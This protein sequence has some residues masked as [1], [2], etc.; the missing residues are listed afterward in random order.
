[1]DYVAVNLKD[2]I[3]INKLVTVH[4]F[5]YTKNYTFQGESHDF[6]ELVYVDKGQ[7]IAYAD[8]RVF[9]LKQ[10]QVVF[11]KP[12]EWH[13]INA[14]GVVAANVS[15]VSFV[16]N[17]KAMEGFE[18]LVYN[19][20][21]HQKE[22]LSKIVKESEDVFANPLND[23][24]TS[25]MIK[26]K[27]SQIGAEQLIKM[28]LTEFL[29]SVLRTKN[30]YEKNSSLSLIR[31]KTNNETTDTI[32]EYLSR[33]L[34]NK[35]TFTDVAKH[36][37]LSKTTI[38]TVFAQNT[39]MGVMKYYNKLKIEKAKMYIR[40]ENYNISQIANILGYDSI[41]YFSKQFKAHVNLSPTQ[42]AKSI[43]SVTMPEKSSF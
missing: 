19:I 38:K 1:M 40:E 7:I 34:E 21:F 2:E 26:N 4:Y 15:I 10:G 18:N 43:K 17:S 20:N 22:L 13:N 36:L 3:K 41:H 33:N 24:Y 16:C 12:N 23:P 35:I 32:I 5:E 27:D 6:W 29:I 28:Y 42:Y 8:D 25:E 11:H 37:H 31:Y 9:P 14:D 30:V 39:G